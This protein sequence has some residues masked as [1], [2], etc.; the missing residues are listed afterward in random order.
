[1]SG[2]LI[3]VMLA[4][5]GTIVLVSAAFLLG[6]NKA[7]AIQDE[8][9][10]RYFV[11]GYAPETVPKSIILADDKRS[12]LIVTTQNLVFLLTLMGDGPVVRQLTEGDISQ[13]S[14]QSALINVRDL[15]FPKRK[16]LRD[17]GALLPVFDAFKQGIVS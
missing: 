17:K 7:E 13:L 14:D 1:M 8:A 16:F 9:A 2:E 6:F 12:A 15:G 11:H 10:A 4:T 3:L 5:G